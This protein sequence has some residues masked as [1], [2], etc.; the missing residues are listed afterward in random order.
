MTPKPRMPI[1]LIIVSGLAST[2]AAPPDFLLESEARRV[3]M[4]ERVSPSV[5]C[6]FDA[7][8]RGGGSGVLIDVDGYGL[9]NYHVISGLLRTRRGWGGLG[10]GVLYE[11][12]VLGIDVTGDVAMFRLIPPKLPYRFPYARLGDSDRV[13]VGDTAIPMGNPFMLS[14]DYSPSITMGLVTG[15][16]RYQWGDRGNLAYTDCLQIDA[17]INPGNSGGPLFNADGEVIGING[18]ISVNTR[19]RFNVGLGYAIT[20]SQI[21]RFM[22]ALR[23]GLLARHGNWRA[24]VKKRA[25]GVIVFD[26]V[27]Q[28][29]PAGRA[30]IRPGDTLLSLDGVPIT[31]PNQVVSMLGTYPEDWPVV[32]EMSRDRRA[33][34]AVVRLDP[35]QPRMRRP[36]SPDHDVN[37][38]E[39]KRVLRG[40]RRAVTPQAGAD[41][42]MPIAWKLRRQ[43]VVADGDVPK[44]LEV[45][46][47]RFPEGAPL[48]MFL[49]DDDGTRTPVLEYGGH[50]AIRTEGQE[51]DD[52]ELSPEVSMVVGTLYAMHRHL[53]GPLD[54]VQ[55][56]GVRH[57]GGDALVTESLQASA[58]GK[59][60]KLT[61]SLVEVIEWPVTHHAK[62]KF[63][64]DAE[65]SMLLRARVRDRVS[66]VE[67]VIDFRDHRDIGGLVWPCT[68]EVRGAG[69]NYQ[70]TLFDW[71]WQP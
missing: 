25:D 68:F 24:T 67:I 58:K 26:E 17:A 7:N 14:E 8:L 53:L 44:P 21:K 70:D 37:L 43:H 19:G 60:G 27:E 42:P 50:T 20:V 29:G 13:R 31:S 2:G 34:R 49:H 59:P 16:H 23:A 3:E 55:L 9:T 32:V 1:L 47:V 11:L 33:R 5:V 48:A 38:R 36:Y 69:F 52:Y 18:R 46:D 45:F 22:P 39:V 64:F 56:A 57:A 51:G 10:D 41:L 65:S 63:Q 66:G 54:E 15:V 28:T 4:I 71:K 61:P 35:V 40:F 30:D 62:A 6:I 12:E